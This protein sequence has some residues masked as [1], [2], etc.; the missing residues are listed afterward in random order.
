MTEYPSMHSVQSSVSVSAGAQSGLRIQIPMGSRSNHSP[1]TRN[2]VPVPPQQAEIVRGL[3]LGSLNSS[4]LRRGS[5]DSAAYTPS[6]EMGY[7][8][9]DDMWPEPVVHV[10][11]GIRIS[12]AMMELPPVYAAS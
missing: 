1:I 5:M 8:N 2:G 10:D 4:G 11:S 6:T 3:L 7:N 12:R 9:D